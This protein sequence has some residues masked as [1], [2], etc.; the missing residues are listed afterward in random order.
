MFELEEALDCQMSIKIA[1]I[2]PKGV[3]AVS[4]M[5]QCIENVEFLFVAEDQAEMVGI[6][7]QNRS[8]FLVSVALDCAVGSD[9]TGCERPREDSIAEAVR[10]ADLVF[11]VSGMESQADV[12]LTVRFAQEVKDAGAF[13]IAVKAG[14]G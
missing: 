5:T 8:H 1:G 3:K 13:T 9:I 6:S 14:R 2:G 12:D 4:K 11:I 7:A 10:D